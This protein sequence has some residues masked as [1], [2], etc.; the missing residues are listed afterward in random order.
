MESGSQLARLW[1]SASSVLI[2]R[3]GEG[4]KEHDG[5]CALWRA[6]TVGRAFAIFYISNITGYEIA[7]TWS[8]ST[9]ECLLN[10]GANTDTSYD[11]NSWSDCFR[12][13]HVSINTV[14]ATRKT[15][16]WIGGT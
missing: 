12:Q 13:C 14:D 10:V 2:L 5:A 6:Q 9:E 8:H 4:M 3:F 7:S 1:A 11:R 15:R 16:A